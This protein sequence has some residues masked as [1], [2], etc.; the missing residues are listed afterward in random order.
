MNCKD[1]LQKNY[2]FSYMELNNGALG[3][4]RKQRAA[5]SAFGGGDAPQDEFKPVSEILP[6]VIRHMR[7][8]AIPGG[9]ASVVQAC[10]ALGQV[11]EAREAE[12]RRQKH[13]H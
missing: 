12:M 8:E 11:V 5:F 13:M 4:R 3:M 2:D 10:H 1:W 6:S 9:K 7:E